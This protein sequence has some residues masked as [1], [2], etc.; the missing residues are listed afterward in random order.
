[1]REAPGI[2]GPRWFMRRQRS[3]VMATRLLVW[4]LTCRLR[5]TLRC[6]RIDTTAG[7]PG[8]GTHSTA[9]RGAPATTRLRR[10]G[11]VAVI[12]RRP[13]VV[14]RLIELVALISRRR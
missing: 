8:T 7:Q 10:V 11:P 13:A 14:R 3:V 4:R 6:H 9:I 5:L 1:M 2:S 12:A